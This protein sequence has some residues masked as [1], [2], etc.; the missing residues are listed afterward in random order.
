MVRLQLRYGVVFLM[1]F[2]ILQACSAKAEVE[3]NNQP[4]PIPLPANIG[5]I[6][7][8]EQHHNQI[9]VEHTASDTIEVLIEGL[10]QAKPSDISD[11]EYSGTPYRVELTGPKKKLVLELNDLTATA[12]TDVS[13]KVY[14]IL[15][16]EE[17]TRAWSLPSEWIQS[18]L[19]SE[20]EQAEPVIQLT[21]DEVND[22]V[23]LAANRAIDKTSLEEALRTFMVIYPSAGDAA[24]VYRLN[25]TDPRRVVI[26]FP[27]LPEGSVAEFKLDGVLTREGQSFQINS[28]LEGK[29]ITIHQGLAWSGLQW[30][31]PGGKMVREH[32]FPTA[33]SIMPA[34]FSAHESEIIIYNHDIPAYRLDLKSGHVEDILSKE[35]ID[36][37]ELAVNDN[38]IGFTFSYSENKEQLYM[39]H[40]WETIYRVETNGGQKKLIYSSDLP[41]YGIASSPD[42][43]HVAV[44]TDSSGS[45]GPYADLRVIDANGKLVSEF[46]MAAYSGHSDGWYF[47][48]PVRWTDNERIEVPL[49]GSPS[50]AFFR[51]KATFHYKKGLQQKQGSESL[52]ASDMAILKAT[53]DGWDELDLIRALPRS[54]AAGERYIAVTLAGSGSWLID[55]EEQHA[56]KLGSGPVI[57]WTPKGQVVYWHSTEGMSVDYISID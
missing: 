12:S 55:R 8:F 24:S 14:L 47:I 53:I 4:V 16:G 48:Y 5:S 54:E 19:R 25:W 45:L 6:T 51:G 23:T 36:V 10:K 13:A 42:G 17:R 26:A 44:L 29:L 34:S 32:A 49:V 39:V 22:S 2:L 50:V 21:L 56:R 31:D 30:V 43:K 11:P 33:V 57:A 35:Q 9:V 18:L 52:S 15:P 37:S 28:P 1:F 38:G 41:I 20:A 46:K 3:Q 27:Y 40:G 7:V